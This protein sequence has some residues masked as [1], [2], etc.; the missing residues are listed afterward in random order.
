M[1]IVIFGPPGVGKGT[2]AKILSSKL[3]IPHISTGDIL[4]DSVNRK[5]ELGNKAKEIIENGELVPDDLMGKLVK[6]TIINLNY[7]EGF[8]LDGFPRTI[9]Q[10]KILENIFN[11]LNIS[12]PRVVVLKAKDD[13]IVN[14]LTSRRTC[15][16]CGQIVNLN[17][18][19]DKNICPN[20]GKEG[21]LLKRKDDDEKVIRNR[22]KVYGQLTFPVLEFYKN[23]LDLIYIN[24]TDPIEVISKNIFTALNNN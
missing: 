8:I 20:C 2:Q 21:T 9:E 15:S 3:N 4:R 7:S 6:E 22:L 17:D 10:V 16:N 23:K 24:G 1:Q 18:I 13:I 5:T 11:E 19:A 14:R 12:S